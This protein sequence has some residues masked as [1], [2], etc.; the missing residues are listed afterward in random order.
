MFA[1]Y[2]ER[3]YYCYTIDEQRAT[4]HKM[5]GLRRIG[6]P[7][8]LTFARII[9]SGLSF[10]ITIVFKMVERISLPPFHHKQRIFCYNKIILKKI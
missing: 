9:R 2:T 4:A 5:V 8:Y 3:N 1:I 6:I 7:L 10:G